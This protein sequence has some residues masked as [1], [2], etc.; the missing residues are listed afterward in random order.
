MQIA[1]ST[2]LIRIFFIFL[3][4]LSTDLSGYSHI[5]CRSTRRTYYIYI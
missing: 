2:E 4:P 5:S 3:F 1:I